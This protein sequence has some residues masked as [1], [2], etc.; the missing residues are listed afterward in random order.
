MGDIQSRVIQRLRGNS[1]AC[2][3]FHSFNLMDGHMHIPDFI[4][5]VVSQN[6]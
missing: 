5:T 4:F 2:K 3:P 1:D 6:F